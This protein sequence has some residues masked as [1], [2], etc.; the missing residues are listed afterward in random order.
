MAAFIWRLFIYPD[1]E[2][3]ASEGRD[4]FFLY[5]DERIPTRHFKNVY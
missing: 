5:I 3:E 4:F 1:L 2:T